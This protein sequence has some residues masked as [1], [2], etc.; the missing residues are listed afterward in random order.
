MKKRNNWFLGILIVALAL[1]AVLAPSYGYR[2]RNFLNPPATG[3]ADSTNLAAQNE[4]LK[5]ELAK[6]QAVENQLPKASSSAIRAMVYSRYPMNFKNEMLID[7]GAGDGVIPGKG[8]L[9]QGVLVG[10]VYQVFTDGSIV[11]TVFDPNFRMPVRIGSGG[12]DA[13]LQGGAEPAVVSI[14]KTARVQDGDIIYTASPGIP[15]ALPVGEI[16]DISVSANNLFQQA[17]V[18]FVYDINSVQTV[19]VER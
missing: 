14:S 8:V 4:A 13:L 7:A 10:T 15:Y 17:T 2:L 19:E 3:Q 12:V 18:S 9:F 5:A 1:F 11:E 16:K 6:L